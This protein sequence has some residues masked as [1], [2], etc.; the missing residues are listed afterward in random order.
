MTFSWNTDDVRKS[1]LDEFSR[2]ILA[3]ARLPKQTTLTLVS[4]EEDIQRLVKYYYVDQETAEYWSQQG[5]KLDFPDIYK[6][7]MHQILLMAKFAPRALALMMSVADL[8]KDM[9]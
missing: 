7:R 1:M 6:Q 9:K 3:I 5:D 4:D 8:F 2:A